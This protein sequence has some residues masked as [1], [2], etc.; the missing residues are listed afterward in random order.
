MNSNTC[1]Y[2][3]EKFET[4]YAFK[5]YCSQACKRKMSYKVACERG[6]NH[7]D[8]RKKDSYLAPAVSVR[9]LV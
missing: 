7:V 6:N 3:G 5:R 4:P 1:A 9:D 2:C 8:T